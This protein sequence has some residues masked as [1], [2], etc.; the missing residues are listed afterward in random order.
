MLKI[1]GCPLGAVLSG[2]LDAW[3]ALVPLLAIWKVFHSEKCDV[4]FLTAYQL[5]WSCLRNEDLA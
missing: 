5:L 4:L 1:M 3:G 2:V